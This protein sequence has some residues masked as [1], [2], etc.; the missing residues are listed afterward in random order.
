MFVI[1]KADASLLVLIGIKI[2]YSFSKY[3][4]H[5]F[6]NRWTDGHVENMMPSPAGVASQTRKTLGKTVARL[7][8]IVSIRPWRDK[9]IG[10]GRRFRGRPGDMSPQ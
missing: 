6:G 10:H 1:S 9:Q 2:G 7:C 3:R 5:K 8:F 4:I